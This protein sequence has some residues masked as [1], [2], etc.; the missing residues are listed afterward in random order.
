M[1]GAIADHVARLAVRVAVH[2]HHAVA[3]TCLL[4][5]VSDGQLLQ[6]AAPTG[7][8]S[9]ESLLHV[10][11][12]VVSRALTAALVRAVHRVTRGNCVV[13]DVPID[14]PLLG[15]ATDSNSKELVPMAKNVIV[16]VYSGGVIHKKASTIYAHEP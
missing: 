4:D 12:G 5:Q 13:H 16:L 10:Q 6:Q 14:E 7:M 2:L 8:S 3:T 1:V 9:E 11:A 15:V